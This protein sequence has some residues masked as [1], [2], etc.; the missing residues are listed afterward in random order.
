MSKTWA[1]LP[2]KAFDRAKTR[3]SSVLATQLSDMI[4]AAPG[5]GSKSQ[6]ARIPPDRHASPGIVN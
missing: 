2:V 5:G 1:I 4:A 6:C 3:L